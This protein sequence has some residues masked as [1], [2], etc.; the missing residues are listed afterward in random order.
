MSAA[1]TSHRILVVDDNRAIH[2]D[3][4][5]ILSP[6]PTHTTLEALEAS[7][8]GIQAEAPVAPAFEVDSAYQGEEAITRARAAVKE[9]R[10]YA[11]AFVDIRMPPG[12]DGVETTARLWEEDP[13]VQVV[14]CSAYTDYSWEDLTREFGAGPLLTELRKPFNHQELYQL[15]LRLTGPL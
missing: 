12:L 4:H 13:D 9:G 2:Q 6:P 5:K 8:F 3:F 1:P 7:L 11:V 10:P 15:A 14:L